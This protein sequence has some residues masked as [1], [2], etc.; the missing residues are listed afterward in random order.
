M[1]SDRSAIVMVLTSLF[2]KG[3]PLV[4]KPTNPISR[5]AMCLRVALAQRHS[6][7]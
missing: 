1:K 4:T 7:I 2:K 6:A 5:I 3:S